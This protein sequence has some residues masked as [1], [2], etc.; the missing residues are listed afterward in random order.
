M[1]IRIDPEF[2]TLIPALLPTEFAQLEANIIR[3]GC[4]EP[5]SIWDGEGILVDG[6]NRYKIC[7]DHRIPFQTKA[8][9]F[10]DR[11]HAKL[12]IGERQ[13]GRRNLTDDQRAIVANDVRE[14]RS[15][16]AKKERAKLAAKAG[17]VGR[18]KDKS[19]QAKST[20]KLGRWSRPGVAKETKIPERKIR[21]AQEI[22]KAAPEVH[23][24]VRL[25]KVT[26]TDGKKLASL[27]EKSR[28]LAIKAVVQGTDV[29]RA[30]RNAKKE[31]Y[32][33]KV[34]SAKPKALKGTY[35]IL[36]ADP[37]WKY[38]GLNQADEHGHAER[39]Y[40][41]LDDRQL[42][43]YKPGNGT[44]LVKDLADKD[45]VLFMWVTS[46]L[47]E[48]CF[49]IIGAWGFEYKASFVWDKVKHNMGH[50]N[51]VRHEFLLIC[52]RGSCKPDIPK[53]VDSV[54]SIKRSKKHSQKP[55]EFY[56][57][58]ETMYD[59]G[60]KLELFSRKPRD[61]WDADGNEAEQTHTL[62]A[63]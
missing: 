15:G 32:N 35:R 57:I 29:R 28:E 37:P 42:C 52:V 26:L 11:E 10:A 51:S 5:L 30:I 19:L 18:P 41:C 20:R 2:N 36:Y 49:S 14:I 31:E 61:G 6:H 43:E 53:L 24:L 3:D 63:A 7:T 44:R 23:S 58:I 45:A 47:L 12:W 40:D 4:H 25:G 21:L 46:P 27:P 1:Q 50:Y 56:K 17:G 60:R 34:A 33:Q 16:I 54:Q 8:I 55:E 9:K 59:H 39:H 62:E 48:R 38:V 22:K 13:L